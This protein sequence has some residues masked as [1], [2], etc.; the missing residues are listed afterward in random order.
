[1]NI[2]YDHI[3]VLITTVRQIYNNHT[4]IYKHIG[5]NFGDRNNMIFSKMG[6]RKTTTTYII[7]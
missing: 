4:I 7:L 3:G 1:M 6:N 2:Q 5:V